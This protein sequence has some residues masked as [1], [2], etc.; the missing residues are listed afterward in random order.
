MSMDKIRELAVWTTI[1]A[2]CSVVPFA[3]SALASEGRLAFI[4]RILDAT[5]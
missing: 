3:F 2:V 4:A 1:F 5:K